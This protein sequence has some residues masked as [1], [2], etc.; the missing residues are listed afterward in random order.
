MYRRQDIGQH[1]SQTVRDESVPASQCAYMHNIW[2]KCALFVFGHTVLV[3]PRFFCRT[4]GC[5]A[6]KGAVDTLRHI[7]GSQPR[8]VAVLEALNVAELSLHA[9]GLCSA[10][11]RQAGAW[12]TPHFFI[13]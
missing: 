1:R 4:F 7:F 8:S 13:I 10:S 6:S 2:K 11:P 9:K 5:G 3:R 12:K